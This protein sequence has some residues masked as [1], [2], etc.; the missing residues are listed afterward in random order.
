M[1]L[2]AK[3]HESSR[4]QPGNSPTIARLVALLCLISALA[5]CGNAARDAYRELPDNMP[6]PA[7]PAD[8]PLTS[9]KIELGRW[10]FYDRRLSLDNSYSCASCHQQTLAFTDGLA[11][12][13]G[14]TGVNHPRGSMSLVN[15]AYASRLAWDNNNP[16]PLEIHTLTPLFAEAPVQMGMS[17]RETDI[18]A[19]LK[20][21]ARYRDMFRASFP[22]DEDP[23]S[24]LNLV[25]SVSSFVRT[26]VSFDSPYDR[27]IAGD[28]T[29]LTARE[30]INAV[31][32][33]E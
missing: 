16:D 18:I 20:S 23:W 13:V 30:N 10:L 6:R 7:T 24:I 25:R 12:A 14:A 4:Q 5:A 3:G 29:A 31:R 8:N 17:G 26:I 32:K 2:S 33:T 15:S 1:Q 11:R 22:D 21:D 27:F 28:S 19:M 9:E